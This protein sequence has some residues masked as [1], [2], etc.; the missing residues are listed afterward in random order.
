MLFHAFYWLVEVGFR[1]DFAADD[2]LEETTNG[3]QAGGHKARRGCVL[4]SSSFDFGI[5]K[6]R[7]DFAVE[8]FEYEL[9]FLGS[10]SCK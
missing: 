3:A 8:V 1:E 7:V 10:C 4:L 9:S 2:I 5:L 6:Y